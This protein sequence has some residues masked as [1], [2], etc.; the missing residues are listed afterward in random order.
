IAT[1]TV[2]PTA[3]TCPGAPKTFTITVNPTPT[4]AVPSSFEV[5]NDVTTAPIIFAQ[6]AGK[7]VT[8]TTF[9]WTND[10]PGIGLAGSGNGNIPGFKAINLTNA[11][12]IA[13]I[14]VTPTAT[15]CPGEAKTFTITV[16]PT[17]TVALPSSFEVCN[18][19]TTTPVTFVQVAGKEVNGTTFSWTNDKPGIGLAGSGTGNIAGFK[20]INLT[21]TP[22]VAKITVIP[23]ATGCPG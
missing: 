1:I 14:T 17:P 22:I 5:C 18:D 6:V 12:I 15:S 7:E 2:T 23:T 16:N 8:G 13:T 4:V 9:S 10:N 3:T 19:A 21:N 20:A 11:P